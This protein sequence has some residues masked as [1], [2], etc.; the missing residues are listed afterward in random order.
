MRN[1]VYIK[2]LGTEIFFAKIE[3]KN[4]KKTLKGFFIF[5]NITHSNLHFKQ[6]KLFFIFNNF[7]L[8]VP[9]LATS[10]IKF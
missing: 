7:D 5:S 6:K 2:F 10:Q 8:A 4:K 9:L 1:H 3:R